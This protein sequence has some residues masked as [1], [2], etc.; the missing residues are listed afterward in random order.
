MRAGGPSSPSVPAVERPNSPG[1]PPWIC[2]FRQPT[3]PWCWP[4][5]TKGQEGPAAQSRRGGSPTQE[6]LISGGR[7]PDETFAVSSV[8]GSIDLTIV[9][10]AFNEAA[11]LPA[12][13]PRVLE[14]VDR[15][16]AELIVL[17][18]GS[19]YRTSELAE[20]LPR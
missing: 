16:S 3:R 20:T 8:P 18:A 17:D 19:N 7:R 11:R 15:R 12:H 2:F 6:L 5:S 14:V 9:V 10:P 4:G 1:R 13:L